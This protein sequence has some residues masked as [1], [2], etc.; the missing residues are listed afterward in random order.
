MQFYLLFTYPFFLFSNSFLLPFNT[1]FSS[2]YISMN[3]F[4]FF[5]WSHSQRAEALAPEIE[6]RPHSDNTRSFTARPPRNS[7]AWVLKQTLLYFC[8]GLNPLEIIVPCAYWQKT[9]ALL[10]WNRGISVK[11]QTAFSKP[12]DCMWE[13]QVT[14]FQNM[15]H[16]LT[17]KI[18]EFRK[19]TVGLVL[20]LIVT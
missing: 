19:S 3:F 15:I 20:L 18:S 8:K 6:P 1:Y 16:P 10:C 2:F 11:N 12:E 4:F 9:R 5:S 14:Y 13:S 17:C 7:V